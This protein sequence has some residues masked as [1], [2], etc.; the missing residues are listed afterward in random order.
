MNWK[1]VDVI[2][3]ILAVMVGI[4]LF[5]TV[6]IPVMLG[7]PISDTRAKIL[8]SIAGSV[9]AVISVYVGARI[10]EGRKNGE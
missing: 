6:I 7:E 4:S 9:V 10:R 1:P 2:V 3:L 5:A 8:S